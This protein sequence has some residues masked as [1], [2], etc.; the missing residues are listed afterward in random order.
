MRIL[1]VVPFVPW[2]VRVRSYNLIP[3]LAKR[4]TIDLVSLARS[5]QEV[6][7][8]DAIRPYC[9]S[10][11]TGNFGAAA[12][13][14][15]AAKALLS[16]VPLRLAYVAS[17]SMKAAVKTA[18]DAHRPDVIYVERWRALQ[19]VPGDTGV[20]IVCDP[21]DSMALYN[22]RLMSTGKTWEKIVGLVEYLK[23]KH[24]EPRLTRRVSA[25]VF[26]SKI[27]ID[28]VR[29]LGHSHNATQIVNGVDCA[30]FRRK[31]PAEEGPDELFFSGNFT[32]RPNQHAVAFFLKQV[33]PRIQ[34]QVPG[35]RFTVV[36]NAAKDFLSGALPQVTGVD[37]HNFVPSLRPF[38]ARATV[39]VAPMTVGTG[40]SNKVLEAF[41]VGTS[42][43]STS[44][45]CGDLP[46]AHGQELLIAN[47]PE[48]FADSVV[49][50][51]RSPEQRA[52]LA[53]AGADLVSRQYDWE[54]VAAQM[55]ALLVSVASRAGDSDVTDKART[56]E[57][58]PF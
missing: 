31:S 44:L 15:N 1:Y 54:V 57:F 11:R 49:S 35:V 8:L 12:G 24:Y 6:A 45:A 55:E 41:S 32:Y 9:A 16:P 53:N 29:S 52:K 36:G 14:W 4:H 7:R 5:E 10:I 34:Q 33:F 43:V 48:S 23:F 3:R 27:D 56:A 26:C 58:A 30:S 51:L 21:T 38:L 37:A 19:Y 22:R 40:V 46:V 47:R 18:I 20:P 13:V 28:F 2:P 39:A 17:E 42:L 50:L 25:A